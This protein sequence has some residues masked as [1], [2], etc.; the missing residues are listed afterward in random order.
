MCH[1]GE[2][3]TIRAQRFEGFVMRQTVIAANWKMNGSRQEVASLLSGFSDAIAAQQIQ[4][5][6][7]APAVYLSQVEQA[8]NASPIS[9]GAQNIH[10][11]PKGAYTGEISLPMIKEFGCRAVLVGHSER[12]EMFGDS[13]KWVADK[14]AAALA[15]NVTP[16]L[17]IG[18]TLAEREAGQ[19]E[20]VCRQQLDAVI[21]QVGIKAMAQ[22]TIAYEPVWAIG[23]GVTASPEQAQAMHS[24]L[25]QYIAEQDAQVAQGLQI[26]YGGSMKAANA[27]ELL[28]QP[29]I[30]GGLIGGAS[31]QVHEFVSICQMADQLNKG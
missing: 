10:P 5:L 26:L 15:A 3:G 25:R 27:A 18:E 14:V 4:V 16:M 30:D 11:E 8:L 7:F 29:D 31:L 22:V 6:V 23:T 17:C 20:Q 21:D 24:A 9:W 28:A 2:T 1:D 13:P 12:R 19:S